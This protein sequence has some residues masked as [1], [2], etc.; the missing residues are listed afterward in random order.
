MVIIVLG[1]YVPYETNCLPIRTRMCI[2]YMNYCKF[3]LLLIMCHGYYAFRMTTQSKEES[4]FESYY[5]ELYGL[6]DIDNLLPHLVEE[7]V[8]TESNLNEMKSLTSYV[9]MNRLL[10]Q[11]SGRLKT[12]NA[13]G[14]YAML[15]IMRNHGTETTRN[16]SSAITSTLKAE[17]VGE[18]ES[19]SEKDTGLYNLFSKCIFNVTS[20]LVDI[21]ACVCAYVYV[22]VCVH[23]CVCVFVCVCVCVRMCMCVY[24]HMCVC[25]FVC[26]RVRACVCVFI[27]I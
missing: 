24:V 12:G 16:L 18:K 2:T 22:C 21:C 4:A 27:N 8:I 13:K 11:I 5:S 14:F 15:T 20:H 17:Y 6:T 10:S 19:S 9:K 1:S 23:M 3:K 25:V 26:V 7:N